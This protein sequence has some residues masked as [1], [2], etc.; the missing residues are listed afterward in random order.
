MEDPTCCAPR[1]AAA[2]RG[3]PHWG[4]LA[5]SQYLQISGILTLGHSFI[6][7]VIARY[8]TAVAAAVID[9]LKL[10]GPLRVVLKIFAEIKHVLI[11]IKHVLISSEHVCRLGIGSR[12]NSDSL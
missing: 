7:S 6:G 12:K 2:R 9:D 5:T 10:K 1:P 3:G 4:V 8:P 11:S